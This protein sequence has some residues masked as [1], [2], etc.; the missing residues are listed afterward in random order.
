MKIEKF[1]NDK[2]KVTLTLEDLILYDISGEN[3]TP[4]SP[5]LHKFLFQIMESV[6]EK[7]GFNP[8]N[9]QVV[10]EAV[11][12]NAGITLFISKLKTL[13]TV[14]IKKPYSKR[15]K[16]VKVNIHKNRYIFKSFEN[17]CN[18][19]LVIDEEDLKNS[20]VYKYEEMFYIS[21]P[22]KKTILN[23]VLREYSDTVLE[24]FFS[25]NFLKEHGKLIAYDEALVSMAKGIKALDERKD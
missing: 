8:Y 20:S 21:V 15:L 9:G 25:D 13:D 23:S 17:L 10:V 12:D 16:S 7:T 14:E 11:Q 4:D 5:K 22:S 6:K 19:F 1:E 3:V 2:V 18:A 24:G